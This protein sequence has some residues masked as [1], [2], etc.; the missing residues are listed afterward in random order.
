MERWLCSCIS[1]TLQSA[2]FL[3]QADRFPSAEPSMQCRGRAFTTLL[4]NTYRLW[5]SS[6]LQEAGSRSSQW[7]SLGEIFLA[8][9]WRLFQRIGFTILLLY[10]I[11]HIIFKKLCYLSLKHSMFTGLNMPT[12]LHS[13]HLGPVYFKTKQGL[14]AF[15]SEDPHLFKI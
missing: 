13:G 11:Y 3:P 9:I 12:L 14:V 15:S 4:F 1:S 8:H 6:Q 10:I 7:W 2:V 5:L